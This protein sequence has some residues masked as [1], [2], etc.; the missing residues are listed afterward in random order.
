MEFYQIN[1]REQ[2]LKIEIV[3]EYRREA[4]ITS[5]FSGFDLWIERKSNTFHDR[6][7]DS[8]LW[9]GYYESLRK[10]LKDASHILRKIAWLEQGKPRKWC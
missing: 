3:S 5:T 7:L 1:L 2:P 8:W 6:D 10:A 4:R 9:F